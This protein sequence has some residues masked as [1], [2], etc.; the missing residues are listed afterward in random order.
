MLDQALPTW[1]LSDLY[2]SPEDPRIAADLT[3]VADEAKAFAA[4]YETKV[5]QLP[6][7]ALGAAI[8]E[9]E[10]MSETAGR[11]SSFA[12]LHF[13][14]QVTDAARGRF[15][16][17]VSEQLTAALEPTLFFT[18]ELQAMDVADLD[19]KLTN[20]ALAAYGSWIDTQVRPFAA[21][22]LSKDL[23]TFIAQESSVTHAGFVR[24]FDET[25]A[26]L[27]VEVRG[28]TL[29]QEQ[30]LTNLQSPDRALR[31]ESGQA[32]ARALAE[33]SSVLTL[34]TN[35]LAKAKEIE[36]RTRGH[37]SPMAAMNLHNVVED[38]VVEALVSAVQHA[39]PRLAH[40]YY[41]M[42][43]AWLGFDKLKY[44]DRNA[45]LPGTDASDIPYADAVATVRQAYAE[46]SPA[47]AEVATP[48][49]DRN[50]IDVPARQG[51]A[52]GAFA[53]PTVPSAHPYLMLN[54]Q[55]KVRDVMTL[56]HELGHGVHQRLAADQGLFKSSTPLTLAETASVF[57]EM[58]TF[59]AL[60]DRDQPP[61]QRKRL[62]AGKVEDMLNTVVRQIS[63]H[64]FEWA[65]HGARKH[66]EL[67]S[68]ELNHLWLD[69]ANK[70]LGPAF[71]L[72]A[73][74]GAFWSYVPHFIHS[75][76]YVYAYAFGD[77]LVNALYQEYQAAPEG[78]AEKY[79]DLLRAGGSKRHG[80]LLA[81]FGL[82]AK[83][84]KFW[85]KG[86]NFISGLIDELEALG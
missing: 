36:D 22:R 77:C 75:P 64:E 79:L 24:L 80:E 33:R 40:R 34:I 55:G 47:L 69:I 82:D 42:K 59:R 50:W 14:G 45:P 60:L 15:R 85:A 81:P 41:T 5:A 74:Y 30:A 48:F 54:Y 31:Q 6:G 25:M 16:Q 57:G 51:K 17:S 43:A 1:D 78:F 61:E 72:D 8:A 46:F 84:A 37:Q 39:Y 67:S 38:E 20:P 53:H 62:L 28:Q 71:D 73:E 10:R 21:Y 70:S 18:L 13:A 9:L 76:F 23:E 56:A 32:M 12:F 35:T 58:L 26:A 49:F 2:A 44:W 66:G 52:P 83:D 65:V 7:A 86:L 3:A 63:F 11:I 19:A 29:S 68:E 4:A 27:T